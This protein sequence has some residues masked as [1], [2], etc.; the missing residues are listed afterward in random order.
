MMVDL[1][2]KVCNLFLP[3]IMHPG[4]HLI[5]RVVVIEVHH[6]TLLNNT[7]PAMSRLPCKREFIE[8]MK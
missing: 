7:H 3:K 2:M 8:K 6:L 4:T 1:V 5:E